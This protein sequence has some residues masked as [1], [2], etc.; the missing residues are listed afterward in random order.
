MALC[1]I[2]VLAAA[3]SGAALM[4][5]VRPPSKGTGDMTRALERTHALQEGARVLRNGAR[6]GAGVQVLT[7][8]AAR[9]RADLDVLIESH[10]RWSEAL[11]ESRRTAATAQLA[12]VAD[13]CARMRAGLG[14]LD[15]TLQTGTVDR[16]VVQSVGRLIGRQARLCALALQRA[17]AS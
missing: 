1:R 13:G 17:Q 15:R 5:A 12:F 2:L 11:P 9:L 14:T 10:H 4:P 6:I 8:E 16:D 7:R 3:F